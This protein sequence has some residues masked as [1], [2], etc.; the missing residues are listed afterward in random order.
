M[1]KAI[2]KENRR[3]RL[4]ASKLVRILTLRTVYVKYFARGPNTHHRFR[5]SLAY[6]QRNIDDCAWCSMKSWQLQSCRW[7]QRRRRW[8]QRF[9]RSHQTDC[10]WMTVCF[11][12]DL[13]VMHGRRTSGNQYRGWHGMSPEAM[14]NT[15]LCTERII[16][17]PGTPDLLVYPLLAESDTPG[18]RH[19]RKTY[20]LFRPE[21]AAT[22]RMLAVSNTLEQFN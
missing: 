20:L 9:L 22:A 21:R 8:R 6:L 16:R 18:K 7:W 4:A 13:D 17:A 14:I 19:Q 1:Q 5:H 15:V 10:G 11:Y 3:S 2:Q 12:S